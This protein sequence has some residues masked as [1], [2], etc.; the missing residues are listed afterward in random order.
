[1]VSTKNETQKIHDSLGLHFY[2][3]SNINTHHYDWSIQE[4]YEPDAM[5]M[6]T[7][8]LVI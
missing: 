5:C 2:I 6:P 8:N 4:N 1:M 3:T 7:N